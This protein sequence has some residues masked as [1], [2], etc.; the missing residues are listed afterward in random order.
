MSKYPKLRKA[1]KEA[2]TIELARNGSKVYKFKIFSFGERGTKIS[3]ELLNEIT[4]G[5][6]DS[7]NNNFSN[8]DYIVAPEPG[9]H[10]WGMAV[11]SQLNKNLNI[12]QMQPSFEKEELEVSRKTGYYQHNL[13]FNNLKKGDKVLILDDVV[14]T[15]GTLRTLIKNLREIRVKI[16]GVQVIFAKSEKYKQIEKEFSIKIAYLEK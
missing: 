9:G 5:L 6:S 7:I 11:A 8:F 13:Y 10:T 12:L 14:S 3:K 2:K 4:H 16:E 1:I 15:G